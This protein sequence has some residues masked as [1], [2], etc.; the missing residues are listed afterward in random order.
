MSLVFVVRVFCS[1]SS[2]LYSGVGAFGGLIQIFFEKQL[3]FN[4]MEITALFIS[5]WII[6]FLFLYE[7]FF[8]S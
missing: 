2:F 7:L 5:P 6:T 8:I 3:S 4:L 1:G